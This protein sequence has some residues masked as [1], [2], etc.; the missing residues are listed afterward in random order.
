MGKAGVRGQR[1]ERRDQRV[2]GKG[3]RAW[4]RVKRA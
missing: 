4:G 3:Q 1:P 2:D